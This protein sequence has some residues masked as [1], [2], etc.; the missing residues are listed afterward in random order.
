MSENIDVNLKD[1][2]KF[3]GKHI[4]VVLLSAVLL[5]ASLF[6]YTKNFVKPQYEASV[7]IYVNNASGQDGKGIT[8][9]DLQVA[10]RLVNTYINI[11]QSDTVLDK[12]IASCGVNMT[13]EK[14]R[15]KITAKSI[16]DTEMFRVT[17]KTTD[18]ELSMK[19]ANVIAEV[20]PG[21]LNQFIDGS[22]TKIIDKAKLPTAP[23]EPSYTLNTALGVL[24]GTALSILGLLMYMLLDTRIKTE[25]DLAKICSI[26]V[27]GLIPNLSADAKRPVKKGKGKRK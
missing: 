15:D 7:S 21:E 10:M 27:M 17:V 18:P 9:A 5:G 20:A 1:F 24:I 12:V 4:W 19:L 26:P 13:A 11:I 22:S 16:G 8:S 23:C 25:E 2:F 3:L 6:I 14:L